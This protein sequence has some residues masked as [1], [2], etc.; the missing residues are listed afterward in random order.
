M[1]LSCI[2]GR[3]MPGAVVPSGAPHP[4]HAT[5][6]DVPILRNYIFVCL[7]STL[8]HDNP[9]HAFIQKFLD[10]FLPT[11]IA[12]AERPTHSAHVII[13]KPTPSEDR[14]RALASV[15]TFLPVV[16]NPENTSCLVDERRKLIRVWK[17]S[18]SQRHA[19]V[20]IIIENCVN[21]VRICTRVIM[22]YLVLVC[23]WCLRIRLLQVDVY[24]TRSSER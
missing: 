10:F 16:Q 12:Q 4:L 22:T 13:A 21:F 18:L 20:V 19:A 6:I 23:L 14:G 11:K 8:S 7:L 1:F 24:N 2:D 9:S 17:H 5:S 15:L 3:K